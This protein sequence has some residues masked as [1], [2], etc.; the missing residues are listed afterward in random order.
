[1]LNLT[2]GRRCE[3][4]LRSGHHRALSRLLSRSLESNGVTK[5]RS[6]FAKL[7]RDVKHDTGDGLHSRTNLAGPYTSSNPLTITTYLIALR[8]V[9]SP[10]EG[11]GR[12]AATSTHACTSGQLLAPQGPA[13]APVPNVTRDPAL[14]VLLPRRLPP[15]AAAR[16]AVPPGVRPGPLGPHRRE[17]ANLLRSPRPLPPQRLAE[18]NLLVGKD[19]VVADIIIPPVLVVRPVL[20]CPAL[21]EP[22][23]RP[24]RLA[25]PRRA[26]ARGCSALVGEEGVDAVVDVTGLQQ[27]IIKNNT[28]KERVT[29]CVSATGCFSVG[30]TC[31]ATNDAKRARWCRRH[32]ML[33]HT[34]LDVISRAGT[35]VARAHGG[36]DR[37][38]GKFRQGEVDT[39][40]N[41]VQHSLSLPTLLTPSPFLFV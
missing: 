29:R 4:G 22:S 38:G 26:G 24:E 13:A 2:G 41:I 16:L 18:A 5:E 35:V 12:P 25:N 20:V 14:L 15:A 21:L 30:Q 10:S 27:K 1:M 17:E 37:V 32:N 9:P 40:L 39:R 7:V 19:A 36:I 28:R 8:G 33:Y 23:A 31:Y 11:G 6:G 34:H 3:I